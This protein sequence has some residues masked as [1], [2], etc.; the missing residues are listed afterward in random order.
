MTGTRTLGVGSWWA[1]DYPLPP[2]VIYGGYLALTEH[3]WVLV[4]DGR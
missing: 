3:G 1:L 4:R 2:D